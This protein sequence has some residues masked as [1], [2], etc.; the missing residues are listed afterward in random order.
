MAI[1]V[2]GTTVIDNGPVI[3]AGGSTGSAGQVLK[4]TGS[5]IEWGEGAGSGT[6]DTG[7]TDTVFVPVN[8]GA[9]DSGAIFTGSIAFSTVGINTL[10]VTSVTTGRLIPG[11][12][13][14]GTS[15][16]P[17]TQILS[18][19][20]GTGGAG[21]YLV[22]IAQTA[23]SGII[24]ASGPDAA[25]IFPTEFGYK[26][27]VESIHVC[28][29]SENDLYFSARHDYNGGQQVPIA[30]KI[31]IPY[32][33]AV[34]LLEQPTV[35]NPYDILRMQAFV[36]AGATAQGYDGGLQ[37]FVTYSKK[38][39]TNLYGIGE[40]VQVVTGIGETVFVSQLNPSVV[41]SI[42]LANVTDTNDIDVSVSIY[43]TQGSTQIQ[44]GYLA[45]NLTIPQNSTVELC[46]KPK[47]LNLYECIV[48][49]TAQANTCGVTVGAK[50]IT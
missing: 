45:Y 8:S 2:S 11:Q 35:A 40:L 33:S 41:Q 50:Y 28:N 30:N 19:G 43:S 48:V 10:T 4:S 18:F 23:V 12:I 39:D 46:A 17:G 20:S 34:E 9:Q 6:F 7:I 25:V 13:L 27:V 37:A 44:K 14:I 5:G 38:L 15:I 31:L 22:S 47:H 16:T 49:K 42:K 3:Y 29:V 26:H 1:K 36:G 24:S 32:Q 21:T